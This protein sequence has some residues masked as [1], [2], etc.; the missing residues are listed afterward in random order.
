M[1]L[2]IGSDHAGLALKSHLKSYLEISGHQVKDVGA[3]SCDSVDYPDIA[4]AIGTELN[5]GRAAAGIAICGSGI[6]ISMAANKIA[7]I[8]AAL[9]HE[10]V[11]ARLSREHNDANILALGERMTTPLMAEEIVKVWLNTPFAGGRHQT[12]IIKMTQLEQHYTHE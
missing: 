2:V 9:C 1:H 11:S 12:R 10:P 7:G 4:L 3:F 8:R 5:A 6:G